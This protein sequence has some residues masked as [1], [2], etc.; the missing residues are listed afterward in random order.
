MMRQARAEQSSN[1]GTQSR[2]DQKETPSDVTFEEY[3]RAQDE[4]KNEFFRRMSARHK[5]EGD[6]LLEPGR[7]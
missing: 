6:Y 5:R 7:V 3:Y 2:S 1:A 4:N